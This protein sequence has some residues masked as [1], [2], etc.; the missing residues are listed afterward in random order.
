MR[1]YF[2]PL[3]IVAPLTALAS[4]DAFACWEEAGRTYNVA[5][6]LLVAIAKVESNLNPRAI[7]RTH[8]ARTG[9][10]D[11][12]LMQINSSHLK[13]LSRY[14]INEAQLYEPC[15][16]IR[17]GAWLLSQEFAKRGVSWESMGAYNAS[18]SQLKGIDCHNARTRYAWRVYK[19]MTGKR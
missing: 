14:G 4:Y 1:N 18:C 3:L 16:N 19:A 12:G 5:P 6:Q 15:I 13:V 2:L 11:I 10:F 17:V 7:N 8:Y 9:S